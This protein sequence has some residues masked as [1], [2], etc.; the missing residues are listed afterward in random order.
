MT[1]EALDDIPLEHAQVA[2][3]AVTL[4]L[5]SAGPIDGPPVVLLHGFPELWYGWRGQLPALVRA[6]YRV[7]VPDQR[8]YNTSEKPSDVRD[9]RIDLL[10]DDVL[11]LLD[12]CGYASAAVVGH[13][14]GA[15][16]A[17]RLAA[18]APERVERLA[19]LN[20]PH[21]Q[22][23][24]R[25]LWTNPRQLMRSWYMFFFQLPWLPEWLLGRK[26]AAA[27]VGM[28][29]SSSRAGSFSREDLDIYRQA[30][31]QPGAVRSMLAWYRAMIRLRPSPIPGLIQAP[32]MILWGRLD[33]ALGAELVQPSLERCAQAEV[34]WFDQATHWVQHDAAEQVNAALLAFLTPR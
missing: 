1:L 14:W 8:G 13:D 30:W 29:R 33:S 24:L 34:R 21:P 6:G 26:R 25:A 23:L 2:V 7:L 11:G 10:V 19:V 28:L 9:Y 22:V 20:V 31:C 5:V 17:W 32:T 16:V 15:A 12:V 4:H 18:R 3:G 27:L